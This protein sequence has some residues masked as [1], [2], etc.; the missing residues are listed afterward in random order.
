MITIK[1]IAKKA[2][3]SQGTVS[4]VLNNKG[5]V[6]SIKV[7]KVLEAAEELGYVPNEK[8]KLLRKGHT[9][10]LAVLLPN[11]SSKH[12]LNFYLGFKD[13][14]ESKKYSVY[15]AITNN[16]SSTYESELLLKIRANMVAGIATFTNCITKKDNPYLDENE[17]FM[18]NILF[19]EQRPNFPAPFIGF[20]FYKAGQDMSQKVL[21]KKYHSICLLTGRLSAP[22]EQDFY[23]GFLSNLTDFPCTINHIQT[24]SYQSQQHIFRLLDDEIP[25]A[26]FTSN[27]DY[28]EEI[29][30]I[31]ETFFDSPNPLTI[32]TISSMF[33][34]PESNFTKYELNYRQL[35]KMAAEQLI[36]QM[37]KEQIEPFPSVLLENDGFRQW[38][39]THSYFDHAK[40]LNIL[41]LDSPETNIIKNLS[42]LYTNKTGIPINVT[43]SSYEEMYSNFDT[44]SNLSIFDI[45]RL[46]FTW[47]SWFAKRALYPLDQ[48][49]PSISTLLPSFLEGVQTRYTTI[50]QTIYALPFSPSMQILY[51]RTDL[52]EDTINRRMYFERYKTELEPPKTFIELNQIA[53]FFTK[54]Y[55]P[56]SPV[57]Y[58][59]TLT[60]GSSGVAAAEF[61]A[62]LFSLQ[63]NLYDKNGQLRLD[64]S[65][66]LQALETLI[67]LKPYTNPNSSSWWS[68]TATEFSEGN[69]AMALLYNNFA[70]NILTPKSKVLDRTG[71]SILPGKNPPLGGGVLGVSKFSRQPKEALHFI[72]WL[73]SEP[74]TSATALLGGFSPCNKTYGNYEV[75]NTFPW[76]SLTKECFTLSKG[77]RIPPSISLPFDERRLLGILG[78]AVK[79]AYSGALSPKEALAHAQSLLEE[80]FSDIIQKLNN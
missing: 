68:K 1:D 35:G 50:D 26:I 23:S 22:K 61:L 77:N 65:Y 34:M 63:E 44:I 59:A 51:Y 24:D 79:T 16:K 54:S 55:N 71:F 7:K 8:A 33:T 56:L 42:K 62:R 40:P 18:D 19:V 28:A 46:D 17:H 6:S 12:Y 53:S 30:R 13:F 31:W 9:D 10:T 38:F 37:N 25:D 75:I 3:V 66:C 15:Q 11:I 47:L 80:Q 4:N 41:T 48:L 69:T 20:D 70:S 43:V 67:A 64:T 21:D 39:P 74:I 57:Q 2:G 5:N 58:G 29:K 36:Q 60:L 76:M 52:F 14:A 49:D 45:I 78:L 73:C 72:K 32:Y 27:F